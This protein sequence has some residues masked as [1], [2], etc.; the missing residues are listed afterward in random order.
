MRGPI[1]GY[2]VAALRDR[3]DEVLN[4]ARALVGAPERDDGASRSPTAAGASEIQVV[5]LSSPITEHEHAQLDDRRAS[6]LTRS[7]VLNPPN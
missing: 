1:G 2:E 5:A 4:V 7:D 6:R 3:G